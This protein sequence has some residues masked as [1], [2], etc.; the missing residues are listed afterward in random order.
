MAFAPKKR[1][2]QDIDNIKNLFLSGNTIRKNG[3]GEFELG[4]SKSIGN[5]GMG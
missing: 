2:R 1:T 5:I 3:M 4:N